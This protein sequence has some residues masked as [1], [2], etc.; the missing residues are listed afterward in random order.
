MARL[1]GI[2]KTIAIKGQ[3]RLINTRISSQLSALSLD[4]DGILQ[5]ELK[6]LSELLKFDQDVR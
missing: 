5:C 2:G 6:D 4:N 1:D 3:R